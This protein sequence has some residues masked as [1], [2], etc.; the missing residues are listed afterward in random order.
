MAA[1]LREP[2]GPHLEGAEFIRFLGAGGFA[3]VFLYRQD[4]PR[5]EVAVKVIR[6][7]ASAA[8]KQKFQAESD[9]MAK[10]GAHPAVLS[11]Y[12]AGR[13]RDGRAYLTMEYCP[14]PH[15][16][17]R[18]STTSPM[19]VEQAL[20]ITIKIAGAVETI[21]R[22]GYL[23]RD[24]KPANILLTAFGHPVLTDF[25]IAISQDTPADQVD[26]AFS[27]YWAPPEQQLNRPL[28]PASDVYSLA[29][30]TYTMLA[31]RPPHVDMAPGAHNDPASI[32]KRLHHGS[33][34]PIGR[35]DVP[36][37]LE[38]V[39]FTAMS[40]RPSDRFA[41]AMAF[42]RALRQIQSSLG[43]PLTNIDVWED[44]PVIAADGSDDDATRLRPVVSISP[45]NTGRTADTNARINT[46]GA[47]SWGDSLGSGSHSGTYY[48]NAHQSPAD[49]RTFTGNTSGFNRNTT[50]G[51]AASPG[52]NTGS[53][54]GTYS[55]SSGLT[56]PGGPFNPQ[57]G[58]PA[59]AGAGAVG[60]QSGGV[61]QNGPA[62]S[63]NQP[64]QGSPEA[65]GSTLAASAAQDGSSVS[66]KT[67]LIS[68]LVVVLIGVIA[69]AAYRGLQRG[70]LNPK[71]AVTTAGTAAPMDPDV[72]GYLE[73]VTNLKLSYANGQ[74]E[75]TWD[76]KATNATFLYS[77]TNSGV[78][79]K[80]QT[81]QGLQETSAHR[82]T[83][84]P[85][86]P[87]T[88]VQIVARDKAGRESEPVIDC[89]DTPASQ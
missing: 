40:K 42:A 20:E 9:L 16:G 53:G 79:Q 63:A 46:A 59:A 7:G 1:R 6:S 48:P 68:A 74:V 87:R 81:P 26:S 45:E 78:P 86:P 49:A 41:S 35:N 69:F 14:P 31:G 52:A 27:P 17:K 18:F 70:G 56:G 88:C 84:K 13:L 39:L 58:A 3:D 28:T 37:A 32:L 4:M 43:L 71:P 55:A 80:S 83:L 44:Q 75:A 60:P 11:L 15:L 10:F 51:S 66:L 76:Y 34:A 50:L 8:Q 36:A 82:A 38:R 73:P 62:G 33:I 21:H 19:R 12:A 2:V 22:A 77:V 65:P 67:L 30:T 5:R 29:A 25:G 64:P 57:N 72:N 23:H 54:Y 89:I 85:T 47:N 61:G 24:I